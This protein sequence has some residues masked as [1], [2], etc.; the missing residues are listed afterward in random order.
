MASSLSVFAVPVLLNRWFLL[1]YPP[2]CE[3]N[4][5][6]DW[7]CRSKRD[8]STNVLKLPIEIKQVMGGV[9]VRISTC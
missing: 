5:S 8:A 3:V 1:L 7:L 9:R 4:E 6:T 2:G